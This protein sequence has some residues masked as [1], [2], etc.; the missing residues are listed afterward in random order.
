MPSP[1]AVARLMQLAHRKYP[2]SE[3]GQDLLE[4]GLLEDRKSVV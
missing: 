1:F 3:E 4:Y 2:T